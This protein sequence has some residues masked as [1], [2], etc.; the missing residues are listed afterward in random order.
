M[1]FSLG[2]AAPGKVCCSAMVAWRF[3]S[4]YLNLSL[5]RRSGWPDY[6]H[7]PSSY[8][9]GA[10]GRR[11]VST[12]QQDGPDPANVS[13]SSAGIISRGI[14]IRLVPKSTHSDKRNGGFAQ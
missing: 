5:G 1:Q 6:S 12:L 7:S 2:P 8:L 14:P 3:E 13:Q 4:S 11:S 10:V 9:I